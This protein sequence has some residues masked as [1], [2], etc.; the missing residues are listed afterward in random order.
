MITLTTDFGLV[1]PYVAEMKG[2]IL[3]IN[4][5]ATLIDVSHGIEKFNVRMAAF[6]LASAVPYF[7]KGTVHLAVVDPGV[8]TER[9]GIVVQ[10]KRGIF[11]GPD[12]GVLMLAAQS[13]GVEHIF[14]LSNQNLMLPNTSRTFHGRDIFAPAAAYLDSG[15]K[16]KEFGQEIKNPV[17]PDFAAVKQSGDSLTGEVLHIDSFGNII[18]N[19]KE[20]NMPKTTFVSV[21]LAQASLKAKF[22]KAY[23]ETE[24]QEPVVLVGSHGFVELALNQGSAAETFHA[25]VGDKIVVTA[26]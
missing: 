12:N 7:P 5:K 1:D 8:G 14:E 2:V 10:T 26:V 23:G 18:S 11:V 3:T 22:V 20:K 25:K 16:P 4:P 19:I 21:K 17:L 24:P 9:R 6:V 13:Q 15:V